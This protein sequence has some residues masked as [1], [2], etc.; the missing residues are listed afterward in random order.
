MR[1]ISITVHNFT[2]GMSLNAD[3]LHQMNWNWNFTETKIKKRHF[4]SKNGASFS[5]LLFFRNFFLIFLLSKSFFLPSFLN[6]AFKNYTFL[7]ASN[8]IFCFFLLFS[9]FSHTS[10][11]PLQNASV[12]H[13]ANTCFQVNWSE[14]NQS[15]HVYIYLLQSIQIYISLFISV[16]LSAFGWPRL[17]AFGWPQLFCYG[18]GDYNWKYV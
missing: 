8:T 17:S 14:N 16:S 5:R 3:R 12:Q 4:T 18:K 1:Q 13:L 11:F 2:E 15:Q 9:S 7:P 6:F 10:P